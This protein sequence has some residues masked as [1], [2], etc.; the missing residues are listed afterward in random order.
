[1]SLELDTP[2]LVNKPASDL[3]VIVVVVQSLTTLSSKLKE[4]CQFE[5]V[6]GLTKF[7]EPVAVT[8]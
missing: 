3:E 7:I 4:L 5:P 6:L 8:V 1:M 2:K